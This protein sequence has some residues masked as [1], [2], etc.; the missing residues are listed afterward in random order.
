MLDVLYYPVSL[1]MRLWH[2][3]FAS[4]LGPASGLAWALSVVFL[5]LT[6]R[7]LLLR[8][9][10]TR[11]RAARIGRALTPQLTELRERHRGDPRALAEATTQLHRRHGSSPVA[12]LGTALLQIPVF[13]ALLHVLRSFNRPGLSFEQNAAIANYAFGPEQ[14]ASFLQARLFGAPLSAWMT[15]PAEQ[16]ASFGGAV[17]GSGAV[18]AVV[19]PL[20]VLAAVATHLSM[21]FAR[22][23]VTGQPSGVAQAMAMLPWV[24]P[25]GVLAGGLLFPVPV[26]LLLYWATGGVATLVVQVVLGRMLDRRP[27]PVLEPVAAAPAVRAPR[28]GAKPVGR[29]TGRGGGRRGRRTG[30]GHGR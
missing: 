20:A 17:V 11:M 25:I 16:L 22:T 9:T 26:A 13:V 1:V 4:L 27:P 28:P 19:V 30:R 14:V 12:G 8:P 23:D 3:L 2:D 21:R 10:W 18:A 5:V 6:V 24:A 7:A 15:M 29:S